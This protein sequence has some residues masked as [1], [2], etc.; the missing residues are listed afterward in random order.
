MRRWSFR[1]TVRNSVRNSVM[2]Y[3]Q[4]QSRRVKKRND[5]KKE[6][7]LWSSIKV[8]LG[9]ILIAVIVGWYFLMVH[10]SNISINQGDVL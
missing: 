9:L 6:S 4:Q 3:N 10:H 7:A 1:S 5:R 8:A 2:R